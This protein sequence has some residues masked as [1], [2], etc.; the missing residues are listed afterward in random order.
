M[1]MSQYRSITFQCLISL[2]LFIQIPAEVSAQVKRVATYNIKFDNPNDEVNQWDNRKEALVEL[3]QHYEPDIC[4][5]QEALIG[6]LEYIDKKLP[7]YSR[8]GVGRDDGQAA[9]E[10]SPIYYNTAIF[11]LISTATFWLSATPDTIS[12]GWDASME[13]I[14]TYGIFQ[15]KMTGKKL[16]AMNAHFDHIGPLARKNSAALMIKKMNEVNSN[17]LPVI[18]MGDFNALPESEPIQLFKAALQDAANQ[19]GETI[20]GPEGTYTGFEIGKIADNRIDYIFVKGLQA[21]KYRHVDD[22]RKNGHYI[23]DHLP[24]IVDFKSELD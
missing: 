11:S 18:I 1:A 14:C 17:N 19:T 9:G 3:L 22:K 20:Y 12:V 15:N 13:R 8:I 2:A 10:F 24:V 6:Q 16:L 4:G 21:N 7:N 5:M 23:S